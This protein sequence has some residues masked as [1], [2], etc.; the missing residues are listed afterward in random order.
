MPYTR[1]RPLLPGRYH[2]LL[3]QQLYGWTLP[4][5]S[6]HIHLRHGR[7]FS[8]W[9]HHTG[10]SF[11]LGGGVHA[12]SSTGDNLFPFRQTACNGITLY[13]IGTG[14]RGKRSDFRS[15][16]IYTKPKTTKAMR[17]MHVI[18]RFSR[19][20]FTNRLKIISF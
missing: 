16:G 11:Q 5:R 20:Y 15:N 17:M 1:H 8:R 2:G 3:W 18:S 14:S 6:R 10:L 12:E 19:K 7:V 13:K 4:E 9:I